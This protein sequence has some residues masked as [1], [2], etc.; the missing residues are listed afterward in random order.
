[1]PS[2]RSAPCGTAACPT[3]SPNRSPRGPPHD[4]R[5]VCG[6]PRGSADVIQEGWAGRRLSSPSCLAALALAALLLAPAARGRLAAVLRRLPGGPE[7]RRSRRAAR[8]PDRDRRPAR[9]ARPPLRRRAGQRPDQRVRR[10]GGLRRAF[11]WGVRDGAAELQACTRESGCG[12]GLRGAGTGQFDRPA[13]VA[14]DSAGDVYVVDYGNARVQK[15]DPE[16]ELLLGFGWGVRDGSRRPRPAA[17]KPARRARSAWAGCRATAKGS[18]RGSSA[19]PRRLADRPRGRGLPGRRRTDREVQLR[20]RLSRKRSRCRRAR[21]SA[22]SRS[23][24]KASSTRPFARAETERDPQAPADRA[25]PSRSNREFETDGKLGGGLIALDAAGNLYAARSRTGP[26][27]LQP[28]RILEFDPTGNCLDCG[29]E[30]EG[31]KEGFDRSEGPSCEGIA[32][33]AACGPTDVYVSTTTARGPGTGTTSRS[34]ANTPTPP[35]ARRPR[36]RPR[37]SPLRRLGRHPRSRAAG[38]DQP[39]LLGRHDLLPPVRHRACSR[40]RLHGRPRPAG[41]AA[42]SRG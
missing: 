17:P 26:P 1:M 16:G 11:G 8:H 9:P 37:S 31:G 35:T 10:L 24:A 39:P 7:P 14:L 33:G 18:S 38:K 15:F 2:C 21:P 4:R 13:S 41:A 34:S 27:G 42:L 6:R 40:R 23:T 32:T 25:L 28:D 20:R 5:R 19:P 22:R 29:S 36:C 30:G 12:K 3:E